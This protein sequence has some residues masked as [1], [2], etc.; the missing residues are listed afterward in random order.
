[1]QIY[2]IIIG[3]TLLVFGRKLFWLFIGIAGFLLGME[4]TGLYF[5]GQPHWLHLVIAIGMGC[6][7]ALLAVLAQRLAFTLGGFFA[8]VFLA[9]KAGHFMGLPGNGPLMLLMLIGTGVICAVVATLIM[10]D[11]I[12]VLACLVGAGAI[13]E[14]LHLGFA[15]D[16]LVFLILVGAGYLIQQKLSPPAKDDQQTL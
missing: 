12:T 7:G 8:G 16:F 14:E 11:A 2:N 13:V 4:I 1:M 9:F 5:G 6:L 3:V 10:D 15:L